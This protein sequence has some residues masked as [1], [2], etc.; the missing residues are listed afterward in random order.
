M[1]NV[2]PIFWQLYIF[3]EIIIIQTQ[4]FVPKTF[5]DLS[6][7]LRL[8]SF[9]TQVFVSKT[10]VDLSQSLRL[11]SFLTQVFV[12]KTFVDLSQSLRLCDKSHYS[13][14]I[15]FLQS[16]VTHRIET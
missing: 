5:V 10:F 2:L 1:K 8:C 6:Q 7:R 11:C 12:P 4:V 9:L 3:N 15:L 13:I 14:Y 16:Q